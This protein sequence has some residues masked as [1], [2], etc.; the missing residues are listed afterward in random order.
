[1]FT[2]LVQAQGRVLETRPTPTGVRLLIGQPE[3]APG[4][5]WAHLPARGDSISVSGCCL[6]VANHPAPGEPWAFDAI[7]ETLAKTTIG[8][9]A[10]GD[11]VNLEHAVT[12]STLMGGHF[13]QGHVDGV[14]TVQRINTTD[15]WR[16][17]ILPP[18]DLALYLAPKGSVTVQGVSLTLAAVSEPA[19]ANTAPT[20][21]PW[22]EVALIPV[23]LAKTTLGAL[24]PGD[25]VN[26]E[27]D[28]LAKTLVRALAVYGPRLLGGPTPVATPLTPGAPAW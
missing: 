2:G 1:M 4:E 28:M 12:A 21:Q 27:A 22:F 25:G 26:I 19:T 13:V 15:G 17:R 8:R 18:P 23:T 3:A 6:T 16:V 5:P 9:L 24:R 20:E 14:G 11:P 10:A 7:P